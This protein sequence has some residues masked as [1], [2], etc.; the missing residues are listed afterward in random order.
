[1]ADISATSFRTCSLEWSWD[2]SSK[3]WLVQ[4]F[5]LRDGGRR[6]VA[7]C[8]VLRAD[9]LPDHQLGQLLHAVIDYWQAGQLF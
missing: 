6:V 8:H 1:M 5:S 4:A 3:T 7:Q 2:A 9:P